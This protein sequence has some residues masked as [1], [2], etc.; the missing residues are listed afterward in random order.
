[1]DAREAIKLNLNLAEFIALGYLEDLSED[2]LFHRPADGANHIIWQ[3]GHLVTEEHEALEKLFPG[4]M[5]ALPL[6]LVERYHKAQAAVDDR[7]AFDSIDVLMAAYRNVRAKTL[8]LL[9]GQS[10]RDLDRITP[11]SMRSYAPT[12]GAAF[13]MLGTHWVMHA[14]QWAVIRRQ[15]GRPPLY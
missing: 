11:E 1:M 8:E 2:E 14:G 12:V 9:A 7:S 10:D 15:C 6:G 3:V 5:P 4:T 13:S